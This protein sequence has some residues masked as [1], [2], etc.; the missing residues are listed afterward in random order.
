MCAADT[1]SAKLEAYNVDWQYIKMIMIIYLRDSK[2]DGFIG[3][4]K[5]VYLMA[6][7]WLRSSSP[8]DIWLSINPYEVLSVWT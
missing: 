8:A 3:T 6:I 5:T 2:S 7:R 4:C 1:L